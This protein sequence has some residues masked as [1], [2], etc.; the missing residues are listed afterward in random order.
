MTGLLALVAIAAY[1][2][3]RLLSAGAGEL[4]RDEAVMR[5]TLDRLRVLEDELADLPAPTDA[6][7]DDLTAHRGC[8]ADDSRGVVQPR[9]VRAWE[10]PSGD[11]S[12]ARDEVARALALAGW[13]GPDT[14]SGSTAARFSYSSSDGWT[15]EAFLDSAS[16][17]D[18]VFILAEVAGA[19]PCSLA[20]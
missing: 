2:G 20:D 18:A 9:V 17:P 4:P 3:L 7:S 11:T 16:D 1:I 15:G 6:A 12:S 13:V 5:S 19:E 14:G 10:V 8:E